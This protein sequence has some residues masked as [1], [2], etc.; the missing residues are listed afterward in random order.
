[1]VFV[2]SRLVT[3]LVFAM[4]AWVTRTPGTPLSFAAL[5][6]NLGAWDGIWYRQIALH[7]Y[8]PALAHG[9]GAA[10]YPLYPML[11]KVFHK[12]LPFMDLSWLGATLST[13]FFAIGLCLLYKL[14]IERLGQQVARRAILYLAISPLAFVFSTVYAESLF[15][16]LAVA[17]FL[18]LER[19]RIVLAGVFGALATLARP[20]GIMIAPAMAWHVWREGGGRI[21]RGF[22]RRVW[23]VLLLPAAE[24]GFMLYL[25]WRTGDL[26]ATPHA[27]ARGWG[28]GPAF[29]PLLLVQTLWDAVVQQDRLRYL[30]HVSFITLWLILLVELWRR[31]R[32][33][34][35]EYTI[36]AAGVVALPFAAGSLLAAGRYGM[37]GFPLFWA[38]AILG[39]REGVDT[40][41]KILFPCLMTALMFI[42][43]GEQTFTP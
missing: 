3:A 5:F 12:L 32:Q 31:R 7:G 25:W 22:A 19:Q 33:V 35:L 43:Y 1:M 27:Q 2:L 14:T 15:L 4:Q 18:Y 11:L 10:F 9:D 23:P 28:R 29:P 38:L 34:P 16:A 42:A 37:M 20:V 17:S 21:D 6:R 8:E 24:L 40:A 39:R 30:V 41:V 13:V 36:F 26:L